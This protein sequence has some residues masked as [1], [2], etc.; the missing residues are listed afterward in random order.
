M[1]VVL[2][3]LVSLANQVPGLVPD[4]AGTPLARQRLLGWAMAPVVWAIGVPWDGAQT[5]GSLMGV[6]TGG[7]TK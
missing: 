1:L 2:I 7:L 3:A 6:Q 4:V 5:A